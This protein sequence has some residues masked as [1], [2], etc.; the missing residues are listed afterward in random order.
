MWV[1]RKF[2]AYY[3]HESVMAFE[4][5]SG[6]KLFLIFVGLIVMFSILIPIYYQ[7]LLL[8]DAELRLF[9]W[10]FS[11]TVLL[12]L[13]FVELSVFIAILCRKNNKI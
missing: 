3:K 9:Y 12:L 10:L 4:K 2:L 5:F 1:V 11:C 6:A 13:L 8:L 7:K